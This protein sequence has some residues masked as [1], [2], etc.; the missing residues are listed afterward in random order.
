MGYVPYT[1]RGHCLALSIP[2]PEGLMNSDH[3]ENRLTFVDQALNLLLCPTDLDRAVKLLSL[4]EK[5][6]NQTDLNGEVLL[7][8]TT[9]LRQVSEL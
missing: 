9:A 8:V 5:V 3:L 4:R 7:S 2:L 6:I 1:V